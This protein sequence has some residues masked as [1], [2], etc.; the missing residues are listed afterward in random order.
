MKHFPPVDISIVPL[1][2]RKENE[3]ADPAC[4]EEELCWSMTLMVGLVTK[5]IDI[6][7]CR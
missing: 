3:P 1:P 7:Y 5:S 2:E 4:E 6:I